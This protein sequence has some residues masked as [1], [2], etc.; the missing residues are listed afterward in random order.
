MNIAQES[1]TSLNILLFVENE[2]DARQLEQEL[3]RVAS[4]GF[5]L[6]RTS[7]FRQT[8]HHMCTTP[9]DLI[10]LDVATFGDERF[11]MFEA[12]REQAEDI[13][14]V[15]VSGL[16][17]EQVAVRAVQQG[18][19]DY[20]IKG[21]V[22][23]THLA[24]SL[25]YAVTRQRQLKHLVNQALVD[26]LTGLYNRRG[27][28]TFAQQNLQLLQ[29]GG[30]RALVVF[31][32]MDGL[33]QINDTLGHVF[34]DRALCDLAHLFRQCFR[35]SD[36]VA[37][38]GGDEFAALALEVSEQ[39]E[40]VVQQRLEQLLDEFNT[41][42]KTPYKLSCSFGMVMC[43]PGQNQTIGQLLDWADKLMYQHKR[44]RKERR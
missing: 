43:E 13:P 35:K 16:D 15:V 6:Q 27:F 37:R 18:A 29:R 10:L 24:H 9:F 20:I 44:M 32:D 36:I 3:A 5:A 31:G 26:E 39:G 12:I 33:K 1:S 11:E 38:I 4:F 34:G 25:Q 17:D 7:N 19:Q 42:D 30:R 41:L 23:A 22:N 2:A 14:I 40:E 21:H 8:L 28:V